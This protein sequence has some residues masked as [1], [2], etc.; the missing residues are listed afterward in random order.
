MWRTLFA[1]GT[2]L[3]LTGCAGLLPGGDRIEVQ[4]GNILDG[5][6]IN[7]LEEGMSR[8]DVR[9][10]LGGPVL[11]NSFNTDRWDYIYYQ[12]EA[13]RKTGDVQH[14][15]LYFDNDRVV[16]IVD[17]Y[18]PPDPPAPEEVPDV[19]EAVPSQPAPGGPG[20]GPSPPTPGPGPGPGPGP[21]GPGI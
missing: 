16:Q 18:E 8:A 12:T 7:A 21:S 1:W 17:R 3:W 4:Q 9:A 6:A 2:I 10:I 5:E 14:L 20:D 15:R 13:A 19:P 11:A